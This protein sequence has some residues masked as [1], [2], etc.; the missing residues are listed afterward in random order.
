LGIAGATERGRYSLPRRTRRV[1]GRDLWRVVPRHPQPVPE[2]SRSIADV[3][4]NL[5]HP[6]FADEPQPARED[7]RARLD[8]PPARAPGRTDPQA[9]ANLSGAELPGTQH[10][11]R[12]SSRDSCGL[13]GRDLV[14]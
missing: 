5:A 4:G 1:R 8:P 14:P 9:A 12:T 13:A 2:R 7:L 11:L 3:R 6:I 10:Q